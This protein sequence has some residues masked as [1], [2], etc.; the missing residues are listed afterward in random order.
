MTYMKKYNLFSKTIKFIKNR[1]IASRYLPLSMIYWQILDRLIAPLFPVNS[2]VVSKIHT[3]RHNEVKDFI[4]PLVV[5]I[6]SE[7]LY[8]KNKINNSTGIVQP[9]ENVVWCLWY[10]GEDYAPTLVQKCIESQ[11]EFSKHN[12]FRFILLTEENLWCFLKLTDFLKSKFKAGTISKTAFSDIAR[13]CLLRDYGGIWFDATDFVDVNRDFSIPDQDFFSI[14]QTHSL[15]VGTSKY[16][17]DYRWAPFFIYAK[18]GSLIPSLM[19]EFYFHYWDSNDILADYFLV[20]YALDSFYRHVK[21][22]QNQIDSIPNNNENFNYLLSHINDP[23][24]KEVLRIAFS[25]NTWIQK[26]SYKINIKRVVGGKKSL[27]SKLLK[28]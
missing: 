17:S 18:K 21:N 28:K 10:Q 26:V 25:K 14:H 3:H 19:M 15:K 1:Q 11:R 9:G 4:D 12:G 20:D 7:K 13:F 16:I 24:S 8:T 2:S 22:V 6:I 5:D 27:G 23:Y